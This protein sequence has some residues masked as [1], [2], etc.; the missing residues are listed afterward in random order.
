MTQRMTRQEIADALTDAGFPK[1]KDGVIVLTPGLGGAAL[2]FDPKLRSPSLGLH[3]CR[4]A[5]LDCLRESVEARGGPDERGI[6]RAPAAANALLSI[7]DKCLASVPRCASSTPWL[8]DPAG[9]G[10]CPQACIDDH[11]RDRRPIWKRKGG[12]AFFDSACYPGYTEEIHR[13]NAEP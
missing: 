2:G 12:E 1:T 13:L 9:D 6:A 4:R 7:E 10:C 11:R 3:A 5:I 8:G